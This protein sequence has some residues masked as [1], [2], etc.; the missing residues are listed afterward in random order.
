MA[1]K[2]Q[3]FKWETNWILVGLVIPQNSS[4][5]IYLELLQWVRALGQKSI[6][7]E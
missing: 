3:N 7:K 2:R 6:S 5:L 4:Y 1:G